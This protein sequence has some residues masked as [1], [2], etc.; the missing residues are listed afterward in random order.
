M[1]WEGGGLT[2]SCDPFGR[3]GRIVSENITSQ[4]WGEKEKKTAKNVRGKKKTSE[5]GV[6]WYLA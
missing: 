4:R 1:A 3:I 2:Y 5:E 6:P